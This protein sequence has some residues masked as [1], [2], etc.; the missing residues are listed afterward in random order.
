MRGQFVMRRPI[1]Q[2]H[3]ALFLALQ[4]DAKEYPGGIRAIAESMG[5]NGNTL[6]NGINPDN[7]VAPPSFG[8]IVEIIVLAQAR[9]AVF[10]LA[11]MVGQVPMDIELEPGDPRESVQLFLSLVSSASNLLGVGS[12]AAKDGRFCAQERRALEPLL[13]ALMKSTGELLQVVRG[14]AL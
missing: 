12:E 13:L 2:S 4:A 1:K 7:E 6:A 10:A 3:R 9:R 8:V 14:G 5:M 11:Q